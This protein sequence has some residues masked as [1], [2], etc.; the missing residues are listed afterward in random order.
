MHMSTNRVVVLLS[1]EEL[2]EVKRRAGLVPLSAWIRAMVLGMGVRSRAEK[3]NVIPK[4][5]SAIGVPADSR[6]V[7]VETRQ[8][9]VDWRAGRKP[10]SKPSE[11][12]KK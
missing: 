6:G 10:L 2:A 4:F 7:K 11:R 12:G 9:F 3:P 8:S 5:G 1:D